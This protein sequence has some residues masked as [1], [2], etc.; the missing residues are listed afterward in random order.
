MNHQL[1][2]KTDGGESIASDNEIVKECECFSGTYTNPSLTPNKSP[3]KNH[4]LGSDK[5]CRVNNNTVSVPFLSDPFPK[6][7]GYPKFGTAPTF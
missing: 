7:Y 3:N 5:S 2:K 6:E 1:F 4:F